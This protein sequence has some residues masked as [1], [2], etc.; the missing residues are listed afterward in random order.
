MLQFQEEDDLARVLLIYSQ[1]KDLVPRG[2]SVGGFLPFLG[3]LALRHF[4]DINEK[5]KL[6]TLQALAE[7]CAS[8]VPRDAAAT[9]VPTIWS[10]LMVSRYLPA[11]ASSGTRFQW[12]PLP[13]APASRGNGTARLAWWFSG[14]YRAAHMHLLQPL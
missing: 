12:H 13:A 10:T 2:A 14:M 11:P 4:R 6:P 7:L 9:V 8:G 3:G 5:L 1:C